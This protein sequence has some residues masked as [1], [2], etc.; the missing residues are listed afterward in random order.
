MR[1]LEGERFE[2]WRD[3]RKTERVW[4]GDF[5]TVGDLGYLD[6][7]G[8][9]FLTGRKHDTIITGGVNVYPQEV[10]QILSEH[11]A[12]REVL[13][14]GAPHDEWSQQV[15]AAIVPIPE[16]PLEPELLKEWARERLAGFKLPRRIVI[17]DEL[18][19]TVTGK[20]KRQ[21]PGGSE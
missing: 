18:T 8:Y 13:V 12:V 14:Y 3:K 9:L 21:P 2:Y 10:E 17:V 19:K 6:S 1:P 16:L 4:N 15:E 20:L 5:F 7:E 11:P